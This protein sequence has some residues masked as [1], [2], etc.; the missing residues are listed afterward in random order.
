MKQKK[1]TLT[2]SQHTHIQTRFLQTDEKCN[3]HTQKEQHQYR[4]T[5]GFHEIEKSIDIFCKE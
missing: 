3:T 1:Y 4:Q 2:H 5:K